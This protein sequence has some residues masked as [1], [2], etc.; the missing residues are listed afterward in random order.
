MSN[1]KWGQEAANVLAP[2]TLA[3][4]KRAFE[5]SS[6]IVEH[7]FLFG[8]R[9]PDSFVFNDYEDFEEYLRNNAKPG[10]DFWFWPYNDLCRDDNAVANGK[11]PDSEGRVPTG[12]AY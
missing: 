6:L 7:R 9:A 8:A 11:Y 1:I 12:G 2:Q 4:I 5:G 10:D 3:A